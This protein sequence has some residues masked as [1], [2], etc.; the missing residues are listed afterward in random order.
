MTGNCRTDI[1]ADGACFP[2]DSKLV[3]Y[4]ID[5]NIWFTKFDFDTESQVTNDGEPNKIINGAMTGYI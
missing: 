5:G 2:D 1:E 4:V 3:A